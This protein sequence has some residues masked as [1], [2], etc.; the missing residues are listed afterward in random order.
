METIYEIRHSELI[1]VFKRW[2]NNVIQNPGEFDDDMSDIEKT[3]IGQAK[4]FARILNEI[5][6]ER[7]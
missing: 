1:E 5:R 7:S 4:E 6:T 3:S 2:N